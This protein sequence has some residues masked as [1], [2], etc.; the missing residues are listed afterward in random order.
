MIRYYVMICNGQIMPRYANN[1]N[2]M[3]YQE[4][5]TVYN[6]CKRHGDN[7]IIVNN[8]GTVMNPQD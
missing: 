1:G 7:A 8:Y 3:S 4:A 5:L 6:I 2:A